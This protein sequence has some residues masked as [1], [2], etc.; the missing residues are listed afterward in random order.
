MDLQETGHTLL[1]TFNQWVNE[2]VS[3]HPF[4]LIILLAAIGAFLLTRPAWVIWYWVR[5]TAYRIP[6]WGR[7]TVG[8]RISNF[9]ARA[10][11]CERIVDAVDEA[12]LADM[13]SNKQRRKYFEHLAKVFDEPDLLPNKPAKRLSK[14]AAEYKKKLLLA[15]GGLA[16]PKSQLPGDKPVADPHE[17]T[18]RTM[19]LATYRS[20]GVA[21]VM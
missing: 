18:E 5:F 10:F 3:L 11:I 8:K 13:I 2:Q 7:R 15:R 20:N 16:G 21:H 9:N 1:V 6:H 17:E 14:E 19:K 4:A 12:Y